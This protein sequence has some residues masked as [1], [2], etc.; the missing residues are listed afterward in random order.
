MELLLLIVHIS[1]SA[2]SFGSSNWYI[3]TGW[4]DLP[5]V[6]KSYESQV[7]QI[8]LDVRITVDSS[9]RFDVNTDQ[10]GQSPLIMIPHHCKNRSSAVSLSHI[11]LPPLD[12][13]IGHLG[14]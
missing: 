14:K 11:T 12:L 8:S 9:Y 6:Y 13:P 7:G 5:D 10:P 2:S 3:A 1:S 4:F